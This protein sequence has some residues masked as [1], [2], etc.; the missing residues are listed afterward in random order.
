MNFTEKVQELSEKYHIKHSEI[1]DLM[2]YI[3]FKVI[4]K[5]PTEYLFNRRN[6]Y[7]KTYETTNKYLRIHQQRNTAQMLYK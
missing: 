2:T 4:S 3:E 5:K 7:I 6:V 1:Y